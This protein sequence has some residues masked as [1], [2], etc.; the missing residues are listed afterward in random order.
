[1]MI[2]KEIIA[3]LEELAPPPLQEIY[4]NAGLI[5]GNDICQFLKQ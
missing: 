4:D 1:M 5:C 2:L 3:Y